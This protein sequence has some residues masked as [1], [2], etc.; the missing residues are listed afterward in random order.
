MGSRFKDEIA[1]LV[2]DA[3]LAALGIRGDNARSVGRIDLSYPDAD[4]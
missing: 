1:A 4:G 2:P 3:N